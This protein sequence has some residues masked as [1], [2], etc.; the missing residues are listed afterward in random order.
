M[1]R[2]LDE[3]YAALDEL[4]G[5]G[6]TS[7]AALALREDITDSVAHD[8]GEDWEAKYRENDAMWR[9]RYADRFSGGDNAIVPDTE[10]TEEHVTDVKDYT[11]D[12]LFD[13]RRDD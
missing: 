7:D 9:K 8:T 12:S 11:F 5:E 3:L 1:K 6:R 10:G 13:E 4:L 2:T